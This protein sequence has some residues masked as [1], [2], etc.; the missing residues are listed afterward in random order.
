MITFNY[1]KRVFTL[2][3]E[4]VKDTATDSQNK[5]TPSK[6]QNSRYKSF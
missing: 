4:D 3:N 2:S 6:P 5:Y 1:K